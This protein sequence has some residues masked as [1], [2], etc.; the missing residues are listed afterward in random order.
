MILTTPVTNAANYQ[1]YSYDVNASDPE[2]EPLLY[3]LL[4]WPQGMSINGT[5]GLIQWIPKLQLPPIIAG[6][7]IVGGGVVNVNVTVAVSDGNLSA[8]QMYMI[9]VGSGK[10]TAVRQ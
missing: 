8:F 3:S 6:P 9:T 5:S 4:Q 10:K 1:L 7:G 2:R